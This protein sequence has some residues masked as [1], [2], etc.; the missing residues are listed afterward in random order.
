[1]L[2]IK[3]ILNSNFW[4]WTMETKIFIKCGKEKNID[5]LQARKDLATTRI[6]TKPGKEVI[7]DYTVSNTDI[8]ILV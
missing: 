1:M 7:H 8:V 5:E 4:R 2:E 3:C 6:N